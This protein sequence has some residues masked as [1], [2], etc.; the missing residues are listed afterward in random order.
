MISFP[1]HPEVAMNTWIFLQPLLQ[2]ALCLEWAKKTMTISVSRCYYAALEVLKRIAIDYMSP[3]ILLCWNLIL[4]ITVFGSAQIVKVEPSCM[5]LV[6]L[7]KRPQ[8]APYPSAMKTGCL[9]TRKQ[10][11]T[12]HQIYWHL[13]LG[14]LNHQELWETNF[15]SLSATPSMTFCYSNPKGLRQ[16]GYVASLSFAWG[17]MNSS[18]YGKPLGTPSSEVSSTCFSLLTLTSLRIKL[19]KKCWTNIF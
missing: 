5:R 11:L 10:T 8:I 17:E 6:S 1:P 13:D 12:R 15:C 16:R 9:W 7:W 19:G 14:C 3:K 4:H 2:C 18:Q